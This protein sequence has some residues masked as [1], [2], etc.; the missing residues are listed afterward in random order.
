MSDDDEFEIDTSFDFRDDVARGQD[1][2]GHSPKLRRYHR[3]LWSKDLPGGRRFALV[4]TGRYLRYESRDVDLWLSS[5]WITN[6]FATW[7]RMQHIVSQVAQSEVEE[8]LRV[9]STIGASIIFPATQIAGGTIN[10]D[11]GTN[12][13]IG[14]RFDLTLECI[15]RNYLGETSPLAA[16]LGRYAG[17]FALFGSFTGYV[18]FFLLGDLVAPDGTVRFFLPFEG[19]VTSPLPR[20]VESYREYRARSIEF[21]NARNRRIDGYFRSS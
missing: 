12:G 2:D 14:D 10:R 7:R 9:G 6:S 5:D 3:R 18:D 17:F 8:F 20:D 13:S 16:T 15:R 21:V 11:R 19:F 1:P 4:D